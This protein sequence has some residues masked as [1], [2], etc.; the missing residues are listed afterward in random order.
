MKRISNL[1]NVA[2]VSA[3]LRKIYRERRNDKIANDDARCLTHIL[4]T[5]SDILK[6][7]D[8]EARL[9]ALEA[10]HGK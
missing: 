7:S 6:V 9:E 4:K 3:E 8:L 1:N 2:G 5:M 10:N